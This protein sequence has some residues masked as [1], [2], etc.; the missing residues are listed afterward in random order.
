MPSGA[1]TSPSLSLPALIA[2]YLLAGGKLDPLLE[3]LHPNPTA[4]TREQ[5]A[6]LVESKKKS[7]GA[8]F[9]GLMALANPVCRFTSVEHLREL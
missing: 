6:R 9:D 5:I 7:G 8:H 4:E 2:M 3:A 1:P